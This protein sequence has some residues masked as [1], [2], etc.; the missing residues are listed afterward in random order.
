MA[1][2]SGFFDAVLNSSSVPDRKYSAEDFGAIFD[3]IISDG[4]FQKYP[5]PDSEPFKVTVITDASL[6]HPAVQIN[7]GRAW[8]DRTWTLND[9][10]YILQLEDRNTTSPRIDGIYIQVNKD[11]RSNAIVKITGTP[12]PSN[13]IPATPVNTGNVIHHLIAYVRVNA[14]GQNGSITDPIIE[15]EI[16][17]MIGVDGGTQYVVSNVTDMNVTTENIIKNLE[18]DFESYKGKYGKDFEDW[19]E[20]IE[21]S[22]GGI[23]P[24]QI[25][26]LSEMIADCYATDYL[27]GVYPYVD[28]TSLMLSSDKTQKPPVLINFGFVSAT[29]APN[30]YANELEVLEGTI[31]T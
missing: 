10:T 22:I 12:D 1:V 18:T 3:G 31:D 8:L 5:T 6:A 23:T 13:P 19:F 4:I 17:N 20:S 25:I 16:T 24:D 11:N 2:I 27:S 29:M 9:S 26:E 7:P 14:A 15:S 28:G 21:D 30:P